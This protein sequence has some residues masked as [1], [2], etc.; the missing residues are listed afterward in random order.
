MPARPGHTNELE[1]WDWVKALNQK[2]YEVD[3][4]D[5]SAERYV[6]SGNY[7][8]FLGLGTSG[9]AKHFL[10]HGQN[11]NASRN[12]MI[13]TS[14]HPEVANKIRGVH[15]RQVFDRYG[16]EV[17]TTRLDSSEREISDRLSFV[18]ST[19]VYGLSNSFA[20]KSFC[21]KGFFALPFGLS[22]LHRGAFPAEREEL[23]GNKFVLY[24]GNGPLAKGADLAVEGFLSVPEAHLVI[25]GHR[26]PDFLEFLKLRLP[27]KSN[28]SFRG[29]HLGTKKNLNSLQQ[30]FSAQIL[31]SPSEG[32]ASSVAT[33]MALGIVPIVNEEVGF[34]NWNEFSLGQFDASIRERISERA[35]EFMALKPHKVRLLMAE[36]YEKSFSFSRS[37]FNDSLTSA[38]SQLE[39]D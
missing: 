21:D 9:S 2:G 20:H 22:A 19:L 10:E 38:L 36:E 12:Y 8:L 6:G 18:D 35:D 7:D 1:V 17:Q 31:S 28:I 26:E 33:L 4:V 29:F 23:P 37:G 3:L 32:A 14:P 16:I 13:A 27:K 39:R 11:A 15:L 24:A 34:P 25:Y 5:R 30:E